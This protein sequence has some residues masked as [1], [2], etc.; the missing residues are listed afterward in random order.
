MLWNSYNFKFCDKDSVY[1][2]LD[3]VVRTKHDYVLK[4][5]I[6]IKASLCTA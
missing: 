5:E 3:D 2:K 1:D 4:L 6:F